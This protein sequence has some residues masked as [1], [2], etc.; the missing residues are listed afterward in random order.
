MDRVSLRDR[1]RGVG[2]TESAPRPRNPTLALPWGSR[3]GSK[4]RPPPG[5]VAD[6]RYPGMYRLRLP[7]GRLS[8]MVNL[9]RAKDALRS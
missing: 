6:A 9:T 2:G 8:D 5:I 1:S 4:T 3:A 7:D